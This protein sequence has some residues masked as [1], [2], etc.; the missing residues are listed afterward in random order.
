MAHKLNVIF[1]F[2]GTIADSLPLVLELFYAWAKV[3]PYPPAEIER[4][5]N[6]SL[7]EVMHDVGVPLWKVPSLLIKARA[8]FGKRIIEVPIVNG[9]KQMLKNLKSLEYDMYVMS[10]NSSQNINKFLKDNKIDQYFKG[11]HGNTALFGKA[12]ALKTIMRK[13]NLDPKESC[14]IGDEI[15]DVDAAKKVNLKSIAV[16]WG[17]N[18]DEILKSHKPDHLVSKPEQ[19]IKLLQ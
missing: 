7:K 11:V 17:F 3:D 4:L 2:D 6:M 1:D 14:Y 10:S 8:K 13:Y 16:N 5:R 18:G 19:I 9:M 12:A 15:R